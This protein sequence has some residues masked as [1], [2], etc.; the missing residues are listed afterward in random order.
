M[1]K[2]LRNQKIQKIQKLTIK[3]LSDTRLL[4]NKTAI[5]K[6]GP[7]YIAYPYH[8]GKQ[9]VV[10]WLQYFTFVII[11]ERCPPIP[12]VDNAEASFPSGESHG[13][14]GVAVVTCLP[15]Y[16]F[17][18]G[19]KEIQLKCLENGLWN[20]VDLPKCLSKYWRKPCIIT[21]WLCI[22]RKLSIQNFVCQSTSLLKNVYHKLLIVNKR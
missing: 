16:R 15:G 9:L 6:S 11:A 7:Y 2:N 10:L 17:P 21:S 12:Y 18:N 8:A 3:H 14:L 5:L 20:L 22:T 1:E 19:Y 13:L 4:L